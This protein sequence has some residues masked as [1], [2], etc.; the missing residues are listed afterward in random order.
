M[1]V[2]WCVSI[3]HPPPPVLAVI[4]SPVIVV[5]VDGHPITRRPVAGCSN[6]MSADQFEVRELVGLGLV[7]VER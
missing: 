1:V 3:H 4:V 2:P 5:R 6:N 7:H